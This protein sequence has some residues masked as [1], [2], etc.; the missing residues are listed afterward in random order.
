MG[1]RIR[2]DDL[3]GTK[4]YGK[5]SAYGQAKL[6]NQLF[7]LELDRRAIRSGVDLVSVAAHPGYAA[8]NLQS[9]GPKMSG[10]GVMERLMTVGNSIMAQTAAAGALPSLYAATAPAVAG[11]R[12]YGPDRL[13]G[14]RGHPTSVPFLKAARDLAVA[15]RLWEVSEELTGVTFGA[16]DTPA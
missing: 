13:F 6:A 12:Y 10:S 15:R 5:W 8:T 9:A 1:G 4:K 16:L 14:M 2:F 3:Q 7:V 11:G